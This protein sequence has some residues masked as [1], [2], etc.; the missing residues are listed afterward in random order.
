MKWRILLLSL[1]ITI[2][3]ILIFTFAATQV[4]YNS[5]IDDSK[6]YLRVYMNAFNENYALDADGVAEFSE[7]LNGARVTFMTGRGEVL[8]DSSAEN[9]TANHSDRREV[10]DAILNGEGYAVRGSS[11]LGKNMV[12]FC[13]SFSDGDVLVRIAV[14]TDSDWTLF[15]KT[16]PTTAQFLA[17]DIALCVVLAFVSTHFILNPVKKLAT[18]AAAGG[19][20]TGKYSELTPI[21]NILNERNRN[22]QR[23]M[24]EINAE[25]ELVE[26]ARNSKDEFISNVTHEMNTPLTSIHGYAELLNAGGMT[27]EQKSAAYKTILTQSER[28]T[29]LIACIIN[30]GEIDSDDLPPYE[31]DFSA[32]AR[33]TIVALKPEADAKAITITENISDGVKVLSRHER[34]NQVY[35]NL[36]R[37]AIRYNKQ[38]GTI[39]VTLNDKKLIVE[40]TGVGI[41]EENMG[42]VFSRFF[43]VD[44]SHGGKNG[45][46]GLGLA[47]VKKICIKSGWKISVESRLGEGSKFTVEF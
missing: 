22:I 7:K 40:D 19:K 27:D 20:V 8:A 38:N 46:F 18:D 11:T 33:E 28:L 43:T 12:Y 41:A 9:L 2:V 3:C 6:S 17:I 23:Q 44:K 39:T 42:K 47:V 37:N 35:G 26:Q 14:A 34:V 30:Y 25:K 1:G 36:L 13:K 15:I 32:L 4:Y 16:L 45:G 24:R 31:V 10:Q 29:N 5:A 21:A